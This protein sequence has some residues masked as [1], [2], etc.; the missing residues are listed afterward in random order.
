MKKWSS[1]KT[2]SVFFI[3]LLGL[4]A[5]VAMISWTSVQPFNLEAAE[6]LVKKVQADDQLL[7]D[8]DLL[9]GDDAKDSLLDDGDSSL[10]T[11]E[12]PKSIKEP[13]KEKN[14]L[15][16]D[17]QH[18]KLF[19]G[20]AYPSALTCS[21]C[22]AKQYD[23]WS[24]S[25]HAYAQLSPIFLSMQNTLNSLTS[26]TLGDFCLRCHSQV[27][28]ELKEPFAMSVLDR[29]AASREGVTCVSCHRINKNFG[30]VNG[31]LTLVPGDIFQPIYGPG[32]NKDLEDV[33]AQP[34]KYNL[35]SDPNKKGRG[36]HA[37]AEKFFGLTK[38]SF[39]ATCHDVT[40]PTG[41]RIEE[42]FSRY[43]S[44]PA[45]KDGKTTCQSCHMGKVQGVNAGFVHGPAAII[46]GEKTRKQKLTNHFFAGPDYSIIHPGIFPHS[47]EAV[48]LKSMKEWLE[49]DWKAGWGTDEFEDNI[50]EDYSF[51][52][53][54]ADIDDR[55]DAR[56]IIDAQLEK[57]A[58]AKSKRIEVLRNA[59]DLSDIRVT[60][61]DEDGLDFEIDLM[62]ISDGHNMP[63]GFDAERIFFM[64]VT[65]TDANNKV[66][67][68][69]GD[70]DPNG[71]VRDH[72]SLYVEA[73]ELEA[74]DQLF[75][76]QSKFIVRVQ[77]GAERE[78]VLPAAVAV[79][80]V[81]FFRPETRPT[82]LYGQS[83]GVRKHRRS[84]PPLGQ[85]T[86]K[87]EVDEDQLTGAYPYKIDIKFI[88]QATP[89][90]L[91]ATIQGA[92]FDYGMS[93]K[94]VADAV[95]AGAVAVRERSAIVEAAIK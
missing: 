78:Q 19:K 92:G 62:N 9:G 37:R 12:P 71:D 54:W 7:D 68:R 20:K 8:G 29:H 41:L 30:K 85:R 83:K 52:E 44:A 4:I 36:V 15:S 23:E 16:A 5:L 69:S 51:P 28:A 27:G 46:G 26:T 67:F 64:Q 77:R 31:R 47:A 94:Q 6:P 35:T 73:G 61:A 93:P 14:S 72:H 39:C 79:S 91:T 84:L 88:S 1:R 42:A 45:S 50:P 10:L 59:F 74:D 58:W 82:I 65:V 70:R 87:Y 60:Q 48:A 25:Q 17:A 33:L 2:S 56:D 22:H 11:D 40:A 76:L 66:I 80:V 13:V 63:E 86:A 89:V 43:K 81:P 90:N 24:V 32:G 49:F 18:A 3:G 38:P 75:N 95:V 34:G 57:L 55:Y 53:S 21:K